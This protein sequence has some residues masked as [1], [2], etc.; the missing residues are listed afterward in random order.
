MNRLSLRNNRLESIVIEK[1]IEYTSNWQ[2]NKWEITTCNQ[3]DLNTKIMTNYAQKSPRTLTTRNGSWELILGALPKEKE[4]PS[5]TRHWSWKCLT[6]LGFRNGHVR[7][8]NIYS[9]PIDLWAKHV[10]LDQFGHMMP[11]LVSRYLVKKSPKIYWGVPNDFTFNLHI[12]HEYVTISCYFQ[13]I[14]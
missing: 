2:R 13:N 8:F 12:R 9:F 3:L 5:E 4:A 1:S 7:G 14:P 10:L 6:W 11:V